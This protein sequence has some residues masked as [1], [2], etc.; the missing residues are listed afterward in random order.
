MRTKDKT[1]RSIRVV[2]M[3]LLARREHSVYELTRKLKQRDFENDEIDAAI[4]ALQQDNLQSDSRLIESIVNYRINAGFGPI[5]IRYELRQKGVSEGLVD[6]YFSGLDIDWQ[7]SMA[8]QRIK[9]F[10]DSLP[11]DYKEKMKQARFLQNRGF[12]PESVMRLFR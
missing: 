5:K 11:V 8:G 3:D 1:T 9:K 2:A 7:S 12:S 6:D 10:G 4:A